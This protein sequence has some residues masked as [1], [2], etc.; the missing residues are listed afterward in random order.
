[1]TRPSFNLLAVAAALAG[2]VGAADGAPPETFL[3]IGNG[4]AVV[5]ETYAMVMTNKEQVFVLDGVPMEADLSTL[6]VST[7]RF[8]VKL[9]SWHREPGADTK[10]ATGTD[11]TLVYSRDGDSVRWLPAEGAAPADSPALSRD[12]QRVVCLLQGADTGS[13]TLEV[14][15][16]VTGLTWRAAYTVFLRGDLTN[17]EERVSVEISGAIR[18]ANP[19]SRAFK[20]VRIRVVGTEPS[21]EATGNEPGFVMVDEDNP[22]ADLWRRNDADPA[23]FFAY[24]IPGRA[25]LVP[26]GE[27]TVPLVDSA[28]QPADR[29][30]RM[31]AGYLPV[32]GRQQARPLEKFLVL[33]NESSYGLGMA[34]PPGD[35]EIFVGG[36]RSLIFQTAR[37]AH[38]PASGEVLIDLGPAANVRGSRQDL[39]REV[40]SADSYKATYDLLVENRLASAISVEIME[41]PPT[42]LAWQ[43]IRA[44]K[45]YDIRGRQIVFRARVEGNTTERVDYTIRINQ[46]TL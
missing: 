7:A 23:A 46:P 38:T 25:T 20:D 17:E 18:V 13:R 44:K 28:R 33:K 6:S 2:A 19:S 11:R 37:F 3:T 42:T 26:H 31:N 34:L 16:V 12:Q 35:A 15:Y 32:S 41:T 9:A 22:L 27:T 5:R 36:M 40:D 45:S 39:G 29:I 4:W 21:A 10:A 8:Q 43:M 14:T 30:F 1:V 24:E